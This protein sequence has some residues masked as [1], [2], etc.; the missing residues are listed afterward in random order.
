MLALLG[1]I[2]LALG[3]AARKWAIVRGGGNRTPE[4]DGD[5]GWLQE[6]A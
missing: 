6:S 3:L 4:L 1:G 5:H 2:S